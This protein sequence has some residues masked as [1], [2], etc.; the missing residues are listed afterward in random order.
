MVNEQ[1]K[2]YPN[3]TSDFIYLDLPEDEPS[4]YQIFALTG[5][6]IMLGPISDE[7][8]DVSTLPLGGY[9][10]QIRSKNRV[11]VQKIIKM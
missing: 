1:I 8:I 6:L 4:E 2:A 3:P 11:L 9:V 7:K 10:L 5:K